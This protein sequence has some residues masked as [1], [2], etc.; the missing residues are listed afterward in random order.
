ML[1]L[2]GRAERQ[3]IPETPETEASATQAREASRAAQPLHFHRILPGGGRV[4]VTL[5]DGTPVG[6]IR[7]DI[8][9]REDALP[10][11]LRAF[12]RVVEERVHG[13]TQRQ[14]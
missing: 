4:F 1:S 2:Q 6:M 3:A 11:L 14:T 5:S 10:L 8:D 13:V 12:A 9:K 7:Y